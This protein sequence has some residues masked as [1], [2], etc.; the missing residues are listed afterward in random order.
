[1]QLE[2]TAR[3]FDVTPTLRRLVATKISKLERILNDSAVSAHVILAREKHR[4]LSEINLH[5]RGDK[6]LHAV[7]DAANWESSLTH[8]IDKLSQQVQKIKTKRQPWKGRRGAAAKAESLEAI[9][10]PQTA[11]VL[12]GPG[13]AR[14]QMPRPKAPRPLRASRQAIKPMSVADAARAV[15][16]NP[17]GIVVFLD[18]ETAAINV[19]YRRGDGELTLIEIDV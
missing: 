7:G 10:A 6:F 12:P 9:D 15:D 18:P 3:H 11:R 16:G 13:P 14:A 4:H 2:L 1:M 8:A 17:D 19:M 5:A